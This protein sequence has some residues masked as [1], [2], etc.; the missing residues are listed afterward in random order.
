M[1]AQ[2]ALPLGIAGM[3]QGVLIPGLLLMR[4]LRLELNPVL[5]LGLAVAFS[6]P[7]N[8]ALVG[9]FTAL[10]VN[11]APTWWAVLAVELVLLLRAGRSQGERLPVC[12]DPALL[13]APGPLS[14][15]AEWTALGMALVMLGRFVVRFLRTLGTIFFEWDPALVWNLRATQ[16]THNAFPGF[17]YN[18]PDMTPAT[19]A[20]PYL[21]MG[22]TSLQYFSKALAP[23]FA[24]AVMLI[25]IGMWVQSRRLA[26]LAAAVSAGM[27]LRYILGQ[28]LDHGYGDTPVALMAL[29]ACVLLALA[30]QAEDGRAHRRLLWL[31]VFAAIATA[32]SKQVG[33][34]VAAPFPLLVYLAQRDRAVPRPAALAT[35]ASAALGIGLSVLTWYVA[36]QRAMAASGT[37]TLEFLT[38]LATG[39][40]ADSAL[41]AKLVGMLSYVRGQLGRSLSV[42]VPLSIL[43][44][45]L[46]DRF[47]RRV[48]LFVAIP[49]WLAWLVLFSYDPR[50]MAMA[51]PLFAVAMGIAAEA[52]TRV[53]DAR[54]PRMLPA[55]AQPFLAM[56][57]PV[58][59]TL[60]RRPA[61]P[62]APALVG[63][64][65]AL[66]AAAALVSP[67]LVPGLAV[68][69]EMQQREVGEE[70]VNPPL[71]AVQAG[72][73]GPILTNYA[74]LMNRLLPGLEA[75]TISCPCTTVD[76]LDRA[77]ATARPRYV[78]LRLDTMPDATVR[79][80]L[81][82]LEREGRLV[83]RFEKHV[84]RVFLLFE[85]APEG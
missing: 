53:V 10:G 84:G 46:L 37:S 69:H 14:R 33:L 80:R 19:Y 79:E 39:A 55:R 50:N 27:L 16:W 44:T 25:M 5:V 38:Y 40:H 24:L 59:R 76:E 9:L 49:F 13:P 81:L 66:L 74:I 64:L 3:L 20:I 60:P 15:L 11:I 54:V 26:W 35:A 75:V 57:P 17:L 12:A 6:M 30:A 32:H 18:Y 8:Y 67:W 82:A 7:V 45:V 2:F 71:Y 21:F 36:A 4:F 85:V 63:A 43:L 73:P 42:Y 83:R 28:F 52:I 48:M 72:A 34:A 68:R 70:L 51:L 47:W 29:V 23:V 56:L 62:R 41:H 58:P 22:S 1:L 31:S 61:W 78:L 65:V 77:L